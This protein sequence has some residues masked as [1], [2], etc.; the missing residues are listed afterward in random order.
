MNEPIRTLYDEWGFQETHGGVS[1]L[2]SEVMKNLPEGFEWMLPQ[3]CTVNEYLKLPPFSIPSAKLTYRDLVKK[4]LGGR[5][6]PWSNRLYHVLGWMMPAKFPA[7]EVINYKAR[8]QALKAGNHDI[9]HLTA[10]HWY[11]YDW[12]VVAG[13]KPIVVTVCDLIPEIIGHNKAMFRYRRPLLEA[14]SHIIAITERTKN[15]LIRLYG[16][17]EEKISVV[18]LGANMSE[19]DS[20]CCLC[21]TL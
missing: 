17:P 19:D 18:Y 12:R 16:V 14:A 5:S 2:F 11:S 4:T 20:L 10:A 9:Y 21:L 3:P 6:F 8:M 7:H 15:D 13:K 1:R